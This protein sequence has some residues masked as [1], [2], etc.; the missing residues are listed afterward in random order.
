M[1]DAK[2]KA[3]TDAK[4]KAD[5]ATQAKL[6]A[7][8]KLKAE[9]DAKAK[10]DASAQAK[11]LADAKLKAE[12]DAKVKADAAT[13]AKLLADA[14]LKADADAAAQ[15]K[16][17][18]TPNDELA[19]SMENLINL[20]KEFKIKQLELLKKLNGT[21]SNKEKDLKDL[22]EENDLSEKGIFT[23]PKPFKSVSAENNALFSLNS[24][25]DQL[26]KTQKDK[27]TELENLY[28]ERLK[29]AHNKTDEI[30]QY[31][32]KSIE[33]LKVDQT[34]VIQTN[35]Q[36]LTS[37]EEIKTATEIE[38]K[39]RIKKASFEN[40]ETRYLKDVETLKRLKET[41]AIAKN[42]FTPEDFDFGD[43]QSN[44]QILKNIKNT[45]TGYYLTI[46]V[47]N[48]LS[49][50]DEFLKKTIA[51][52]QK[53]I[54]FFYD[55]N[56]SRYFIYYTKYNTIEEAKKALEAKGSTP[57]NGKMVIVKVEN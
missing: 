36:L 28:K 37:L 39:R 43:E 18:I 50:R 46:A 15:E 29:K 56:T 55:V 13:Q 24:E 44:M 5:A 12:T 2:L 6:L 1:A 34:K 40:D 9:T 27:I 54:D 51:T 30:A 35:T 23:Q 19:K 3:E 57:Y 45:N 41:T 52:G 8:A 22:K 11:L 31:Y 20:I 32:L 7:D 14:K 53:N 21:V 38:K 25:I 33:S 26:I 10:T 4:V 47:H 42:N 16:L 49:K 48:D 17:A